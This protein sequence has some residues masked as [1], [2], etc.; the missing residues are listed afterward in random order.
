M[1]THT[2][3]AFVHDSQCVAAILPQPG[4][5]METSHQFLPAAPSR[6]TMGLEK[7]KGGVGEM[8]WVE[9]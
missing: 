9:G 5:V 8:R 1:A 3:S 6:G 4:H 2:L 7:E